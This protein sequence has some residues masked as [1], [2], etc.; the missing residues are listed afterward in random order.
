MPVRKLRLF[1]IWIAA[2]VVACQ[3]AAGP[4]TA[5]NLPVGAPSIQ[6][7]VEPDVGARPV[8]QFIDAANQS[9]D[10]AMYLLSDRPI[11]SAIESAKRRGVLV[12]VMLEEHPYGEGAG[13]GSIY[14]RLRGEGILVAWSPA[15]FKLSHDKYAVADRRSALLGTANWT[16]SAFSSNREYVV[17]DQDAT[18]VA[19]VAAIFDADWSRRVAAVDDPHLVVSPTNSRADF[20]A[21]IRTAHKQIDLEAEEMQDQEIEDALGQAAQRGITVRAIVPTSSGGADANEP[22]QR[23]LAGAGVKVRRLENPYVHAKDILIDGQE[24]FIGSE[25]ISSQSLDQNREI[26]IVTVDPAAVD[27]L[28]QTFALDWASAS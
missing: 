16:A 23:R 14:D 12:R 18:D 13:N 4:S 9:L 5:G 26:G 11:I 25:N 10:V 19:Q 28:E 15:D 8:I 2:G 21:L 1:L 22:G 17:V 7:Y 24:A 6:L 3:P 20:L 27:R